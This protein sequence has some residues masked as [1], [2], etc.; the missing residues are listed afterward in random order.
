MQ[1]YLSVAPSVVPTAFREVDL[2][3]LSSI[4]AAVAW[5]QEL[6]TA[7]GEGMV[8]KPASPVV[9]GKRGV[10]QPGIK[11]RG[12]DY[13]R[14]IYGPEYLMPENLER[15]RPRNVSAK[16]SLAL[17]EFALGLEALERFVRGSPL[18]EV[19]ECIA[20]VLALEIEVLDPRL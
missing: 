10:V 4:D 16:R 17:Q 13:L 6:T 8:V 3:N 19:H 18:R 11:V 2:S 7:G 9:S 15:L 5:W 14:L 1:R 20:G 12:R